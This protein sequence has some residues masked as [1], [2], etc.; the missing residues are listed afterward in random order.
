MKLKR[1]T[2]ILTTLL[3]AV[4]FMTAQETKAKPIIVVIPFEAKNVEICKK[5]L[6]GLRS[7]DI[8]GNGLN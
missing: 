7:C 1:I 3:L 5:C 8:I 4:S 2:L 6:K